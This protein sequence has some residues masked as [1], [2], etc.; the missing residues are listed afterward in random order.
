MCQRLY[1]PVPRI[2]NG[3]PV[4]IAPMASMGCEFLAEH[5]PLKTEAGE[6]DKP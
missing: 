4:R 3:E 2:I 5:G 6:Q 1:E